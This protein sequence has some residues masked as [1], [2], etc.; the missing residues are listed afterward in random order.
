[1]KLLQ[2]ILLA[3]P[4]L[5]LLPLHPLASPAYDEPPGTRPSNSHTCVEKLFLKTTCY[6]VIQM[7]GPDIVKLLTAGMNADVVCHTLEFCKQDAGQPLCHLYAPPKEPWR[8][9]LEKARQLVEKSPAL[10]RPRSGSDIC[11]LPFLAK[12]CQEIK[13][14]IQNSVPFKDADSDKYSVF[15]AL[16]GYH[17][18]GRDCNDSDAT[19]YPGRRP[20]NWDA[21]RDSNCNGIWGV[22]PSDGIPYEKKFCEG[23]QPRGI[24][25]L[26]DS[27]G[28]HFHIA[29][30]W[31]TAAQMSLNSFFNLPTALADELDWP[32]VSGV[33]GFLSSMSGIKEKSIY[34]RLRERNR[35]NHR[36]YQNISRNGASS[37]NLK[38]F[39]ESLS[40]SKL[41]DHPAVVI[42]AMIGNDVCNG[43]RDPVPAMTTPEK[44]YSHVMQTLQQLH[45][46]LPNGSSVI[47]YGLP[48]GT[49]LWDNLHSRYHPLGQLNRDV[50]YAQLYAFLNCLQVS[51]CHGWMSSNKTLRALTSERAKQLSKTLERIADSERFTN[52]NLFYMDFAF[53]EITEE[54]RKRGGQPWQLIEPVDGFHP[55]EARPRRLGSIGVRRERAKPSLRDLRSSCLG[56]P[57]QPPTLPSPSDWTHTG[58]CGLTESEGTCTNVGRLEIFEKLL[59]YFLLP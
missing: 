6:L 21:H 42:Y 50:T 45:S 25:L 7:F 38:Q 4:L 56:S 14:A 1:M 27:F 52:L 16:R 41:W 40:R 32:Q 43:K 33:T 30:E 12:I 24:V 23:S 18:R 26:G 54:W 59:V 57:S 51:P 9:T 5:F 58:P 55:N 3:A 39:I 48:D 53:Q 11:S 35:C 28:A 10:K 44:L 8:Q 19:V 15:S 29:P 22:D 47:F 49:F 37:Q 13:L 2:E 20:D 17:W 36:D 34:R 31:V 46:H